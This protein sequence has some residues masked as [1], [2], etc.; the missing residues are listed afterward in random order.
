[1]DAKVTA[2]E[3]RWLRQLLGPTQKKVPEIV[4]RK[5]VSLGFAVQKV[6]G[7]SITA[8]GRTAVSRNG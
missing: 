5:L 3:V 8:Q 4:E 6:G 1:M 7:L 2:E